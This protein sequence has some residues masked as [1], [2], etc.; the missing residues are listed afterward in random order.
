M[1]KSEVLIAEN[2][3]GFCGARN[4][5]RYLCEIRFLFLFVV[6]RVVRLNAIRTI[7]EE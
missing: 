2:R 7:E 1:R 4:R 5:T 6:A 3:D